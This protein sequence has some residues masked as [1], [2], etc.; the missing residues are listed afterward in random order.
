MIPSCSRHASS[1]TVWYDVRPFL[2]ALCRQ[3]LYQERRKCQLSQL[4]LSTTW[5]VPYGQIQYQRVVS[6]TWSLEVDASHLHR[7]CGVMGRN[8]CVVQ[9][10]LCPRLRL[11]SFATAERPGE[12]TNKMIYGTQGRGRGLRIQASTHT[13]THT[14]ITNYKHLFCWGRLLSL[15]L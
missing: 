11:F 1:H 2:G 4:L 13:H 14:E 8:V 9:Q 3:Y 6:F 10:A 5:T 7:V 15:P 12:K